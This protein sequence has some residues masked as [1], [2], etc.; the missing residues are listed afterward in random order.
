MIEKSL[1]SVIELGAPYQCEK[2]LESPSEA[3]CKDGAQTGSKQL[4]RHS[5]LVRDCKEQSLPCNNHKLYECFWERLEWHW[6]DYEWQVL[7]WFGVTV[8]LILIAIR[9]MVCLLD[10]ITQI[11]LVNHYP[12]T[13]TWAEVR[14]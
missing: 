14:A 2:E 11:C 4:T 10:P 13:E 5:I 3:Q 7:I 8:S 1:D 6:G 9:Y 12:S